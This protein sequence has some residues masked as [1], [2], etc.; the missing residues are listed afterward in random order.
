M[1]GLML[2][3]LHTSDLHLGA[4]L[5]T[6]KRQREH[7]L[8][9]DWLFKKV[10]EFKIDV[11]LICGDIFDSTTPPFYAQHLY[12]SFLARIIKLGFC[13]VVI[14]GGNHDSPSF[15]R[16]PL[17]L[18]EFF[19]VFVITDLRDDSLLSITGDN[20]EI[21]AIVGAV[22]YL[23][24]V[25]LLHAIEGSS[26]SERETLLKRAIE[27]HYLDIISRGREIKSSLAY[28]VPFILTGHLLAS[29]GCMENND[30]IRDLYVGGIGAVDVE[31]WAEEVSYIALGHIHSFQRI[32]PNVAYSG[33]PIPMGFNEASFA[34]YVCILEFEED[35][36]IDF[37]TLQ[38]PQ[39]QRLER[40]EG[41]MQ[42]IEKKL[43][44]LKERGEEIWVE[45]V[46]TGEEVVADLRKKVEEMVKDSEIEVLVVKNR[47]TLDGILKRDE[48]L[49]DLR[50]ISPLE[51]F[52][53]K[54]EMEKVPVEQR[55]EMEPLFLEIL[56]SILDESYG[57]VP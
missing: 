34:K 13:R 4:R 24:E 47:L 45:V 15:L 22:P 2:R 51:I 9:L 39:I 55:G 25:E 36:L 50:E 42:A 44:Y 26:L 11:L 21:K 46:Y 33:S 54:M 23:R 17:P 27:G 8:F 12:F 1:D 28:P 37:S 19:D 41:D 52:R 7:E 32:F 14:I 30:R 16:A 56:S 35:V 10:E 29:R 57:T 53:R 18:L 43:S 40:V 48:S 6:K 38:V 31:R 20:G 3:V 49:L 5:Y